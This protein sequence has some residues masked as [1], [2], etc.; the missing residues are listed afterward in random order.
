M[1]D[2]FG[3]STAPVSFEKTIEFRPAYDKRDPNP[4]KNYG[5]HG[6]DMCWYLKGP[7]GVIQFVVFN[8]FHKPTP[9]YLDY[10][11]YIPMYE[12]QTSADCHLV[13]KCFYGG[14]SLQVHSIFTILLEKGSDGVWAALE[15]R[16]NQL[17]PEA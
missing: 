17:W 13:D 10:H 4:L 3:L 11:S 6:V 7:K 5:I 9:A 8:V 15:E 16:Y 1:K 12:G 14:S 2:K